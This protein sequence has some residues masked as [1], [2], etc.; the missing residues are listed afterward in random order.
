M[1][2]NIIKKI[3]MRLEMRNQLFS[4]KLRDHYREL[5]EIDVGLY[6]YGCFDPRR[7]GRRTT[8][9]RYCSF[10]PSVF[11]YTRNHPVEFLSTHPFLFNESLGFPVRRNV[12]Y[13]PCTIQDDVWFGHMA[14][15]LPTV[16]TI[17]RGAIVAAGSV[18]TKDVRPYSIVGGNP[19]KHIRLRFS[20]S[21][22]D[23]LEKT[24]WWEM[25]SA[26]LAQFCKANEQLA[27][28]PA[29]FLANNE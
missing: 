13:S 7:I 28:T 23:E 18:V 29:A 3:V 16:R 17:G 6:S 12:P 26:Q 14:T 8:I 10:A 19:A 15:V 11:V 5:H 24:K 27:F 21:V 2:N 25:D 1:L 9:G 20:P 4:Q 22:I